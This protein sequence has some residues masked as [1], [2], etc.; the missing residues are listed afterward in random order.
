[1]LTSFQMH[2]ISP[3]QCAWTHNLGFHP[4][5]PLSAQ[6]SM[7]I[8]SPH[9]D[10]QVCLNQIAAHVYA[11]NQPMIGLA[12]GFK[13]GFEDIL[14]SQTSSAPAQSSYFM[15][16]VTSWYHAFA[17]FFDEA[18]FKNTALHRAISK[19][20]LPNLNQALAQHP[21][22]INQLNYQGTAPL[23]MAIDIGDFTAVKRLVQE[24]ADLNVS[25]GWLEKSPC[26][27]ALENQHFDI[28]EFIFDNGGR[29]DAQN[30]HL[31]HKYAQMGHLERLKKRLLNPSAHLKAL[32]KNG[33][34]PL[35]LAIKR[36]H[37]PLK[38]SEL[39]SLFKTIKYLIDNDP[40]L[41][42][43]AVPPTKGPFPVHPMDQEPLESVTRWLVSKEQEDVLLTVEQYLSVQFARKFKIRHLD[44]FKWTPT[45]N[46]EGAYGRLYTS[47]DHDTYLI[48]SP[49]HQYQVILQYLV[50]PIYQHFLDQKVPL[51]EVVINQAGKLL[52]CTP[53]DK[54]FIPLSE[55]SKKMCA[56]SVPKGLSKHILTALVLENFEVNL[57]HYGLI[58]T[59]EGEHIIVAQ[60][61]YCFLPQFFKN[62][63]LHQLFDKMD[64]P[65]QFIEQ[66]F[67]VIN[68]FQAQHPSLFNRYKNRENLKQALKEL[69]QMDIEQLCKDLKPRFDT[70]KPIILGRFGP[71]F[72]PEDFDKS[73]QDICNI[74]KNRL[75]QLS[76]IYGYLTAQKEDIQQ[77]KGT[78]LRFKRH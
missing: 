75:G 44:S 3:S 5:S 74:L 15:K 23:H 1:M 73:H 35:S 21:Q 32:D 28:A 78:S 42:N 77:T 22:K 19:Q 53:F 71:K 14:D 39:T 52:I 76:R 62:N 72:T 18:V 4:P 10:T 55:F 26:L 40:D 57:D 56:R 41:F 50:S 68:D 13:K 29:I 51:N 36:L 31:I 12:R 24:G 54:D 27:I 8:P 70:L 2:P 25:R 66:F 30:R 61:E 63:I 65:S 7:S 67:K 37:M 34:T 11:G 16:V 58:P 38:A 20:S 48:P 9:F 47:G 43:T 69:S 49:I 6:T 17:Q 46:P 59:A 45:L 60:Y 33:D 64:T